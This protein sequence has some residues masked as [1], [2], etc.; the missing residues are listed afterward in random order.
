MR[1]SGK[2]KV[3]IVD[4]DDRV[5]WKFQESLENAGFDTTATWSGH[6]A[7]VLLKSGVFDVLLV[8]EYLP[9][10]HSHDFLERVRQLLTQPS[11][12]V[13]HDSVAQPGDLRCY[14]S[15]S[16][17]ELVDKRDPVKVCKAVSFC[18]EQPRKQMARLEHLCLPQQR[19]SGRA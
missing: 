2:A 5:L 19:R 10:L 7:L 12:V 15:L 3:L 11:I 9:D 1:S 14:E 18:A 6:E 16:V 17:S 13:M 4:N 8:D